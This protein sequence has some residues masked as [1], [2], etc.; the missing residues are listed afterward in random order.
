MQDKRCD[1]KPYIMKYTVKYMPK[2]RIKHTIK[3]RVNCFET[4]L[5]VLNDKKPC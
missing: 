3:W 5:G 1:N 4:A 2:Q